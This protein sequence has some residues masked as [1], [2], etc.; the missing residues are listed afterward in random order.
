[1]PILFVILGLLFPRALIIV[2]WI[3]TDWFGGIFDSVVFLI[4][5]LFFLPVSILWYS[6]VMYYFAGNWTA[7]PIIGMVIAVLIDT[8]SLRS[9]RKLAKE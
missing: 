3:F 8:G 7:I 2:L 5:G 4:L 9:S 6:A 1:M